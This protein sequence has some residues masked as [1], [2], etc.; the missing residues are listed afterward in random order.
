[1]S[2]NNNSEFNAQM[3]IL[4]HLA[5]LIGNACK[6]EID[7]RVWENVTKYLLKDSENAKDAFNAIDKFL[8]NMYY[9]VESR[10]IDDNTVK[11]IK[12]ACLVLDVVSKYEEISK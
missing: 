3:C 7:I 1:M 5:C 12:K 6:M 4:K 8:E 2:D 11:E 10:S 9:P